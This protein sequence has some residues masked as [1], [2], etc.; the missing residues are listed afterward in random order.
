MMEKA[1]GILLGMGIACSASAALISA[2][3]IS[4]VVDDGTPAWTGATS[5]NRV[6]EPNDNVDLIG[7]VSFDLSSYTGDLD[8]ATF[9]LNFGLTQFSDSP[10]AMNIEYIGTFA[11][12]TMGPSGTANITTWQGTAAL[13]S[14]I[15]LDTVGEYNQAIDLSD[16]SFDEDYAVFRFTTPL[17]VA[18]SGE[19]GQWDVG[20]DITLDV[21][22]EPATLGLMVTFGGAAL[23]IRRRMML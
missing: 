21:V 20:S 12:D 15:G 10:E 14:V 8:A 5:I 18:T 16:G 13:N 22:P 23:F 6:G 4:T 2:S 17:T 19:Y 1:I 11:D 7:Y 3:T 9:A